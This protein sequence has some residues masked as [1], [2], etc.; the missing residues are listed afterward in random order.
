M[1]TA[2]IESRTRHD[3]RV[4]IRASRDPQ[5]LKVDHI[6]EV[7]L[8]PKERRVLWTDDRASLF[9]IS[10]DG[11]D[12]WLNPPELKRFRSLSGNLHGHRFHGKPVR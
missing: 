10:L 9:E 2:A 8:P 7:T 3:A 4:W 12:P 6:R 5:A 1:T 11:I